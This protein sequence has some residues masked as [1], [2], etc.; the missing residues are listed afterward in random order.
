MSHS[1]SRPALTT[2][3]KDSS[4]PVW[5]WGV[6]FAPLTLAETVQR[7]AALVGQNQPAFFITAN[8]HY[9][10]LT[11][12][13]PDLFEVNERAAFIVAEHSSNGEHAGVREFASEG[14]L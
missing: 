1:R 4:A 8:S 6:P 7:V 5:I 10:M 13:H 3:P 14:A 2:S 9:V 11:H 12:E